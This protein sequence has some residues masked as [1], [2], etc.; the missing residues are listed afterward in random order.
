MSIANVPALRQPAHAA[1]APAPKRPIHA[2]NDARPS[3]AVNTHPRT[4]DKAGVLNR[5]V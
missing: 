2:D 4:P 5:L 1:P 3:S